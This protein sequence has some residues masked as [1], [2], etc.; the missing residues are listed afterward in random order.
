MIQPPNNG[1]LAKE[2]NSVAENQ[3]LRPLFFY[4]T[5]LSNTLSFL[6]CP[7]IQGKI[8]LIKQRFNYDQ[9]G[10]ENI[11]PLIIDVFNVLM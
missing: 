1:S 6:H 3:H 8:A 11:F 2:K 9:Q 4:I 10:F 5:I 7:Y